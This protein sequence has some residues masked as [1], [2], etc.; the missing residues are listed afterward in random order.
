[1]DQRA[2]RRDLLQPVI[3]GDPLLKSLSPASQSLLKTALQPVDLDEDDILFRCDA[4]VD[5]CYFIEDGALRV[6]LDDHAGREVWLAILGKGDWV[7]EVGLLDRQPRSATV[8]A[9]TTCRLWRLPL[10][11]FDSLCQTDITFYR[12]MVQLIAFRLRSANCEVRDQRLDL[13]ARLAKTMLKLAAAFGK[14]LSDGR[15]LIDCRIG[16]ARLAEITGATRENVNRQF[17]NWRA[18]RL[19]ERIGDQYCLADLQKWK[20]LAEGYSPAVI[21]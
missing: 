4:P 9:M 21:T 6:C 19:C 13:E 2:Q 7:G 11:A 10:A 5:G 17:K 15:M 18:L 16:Q 8:A 3:S 12:S 1:M 20:S 14:A